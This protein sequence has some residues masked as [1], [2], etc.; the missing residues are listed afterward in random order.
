MNII[1]YNDKI[2]EIK[3]DDIIFQGSDID[4]YN[5][6]EINWQLL[7]GCNY[8]CSYCFG[9]E[10]LS[11]DFI[12]LQ[13]LKLAVDKIFQIEK[14]YYTFTLLGGEPTY[15][16]DFLELIKYIYSFTNK[17]I[18]ILVV[19]NASRN[20]EYFEKLLQ[21]VGNN[22][23]YM[24]FSVH[25]EYADI[26]HIKELILL[27][28]KYK[29]NIC[30][31][32]MLH[33]EYEEKIKNYIYEIFELNKI[34]NFTFNLAFLKEPP[35]F[36][37]ID[38]RYSKNFIDFINS[39][40]KLINEKKFNTYLDVMFPKVYFSLRNIINISIDI[41]FLLLNNL[42]I[43]KEF[44]CCGGINLISIEPNGDYRGAVC[45]EFPIVGNIYEED[46]INWFKLACIRKCNVAQCGCITNDRCNKYRDINKAKNY[47]LE[48]RKKYLNLFLLSLLNKFDEDIDNINKDIKLLDNK[49]ITLGSKMQHINDY[50]DILV[51]TIA[52]WIPIRKWRDNFRSKFA[53]ADQ[54]RPDQTRPDLIVICKGY[55][56]FYNNSK[57]KKLQP[58]LHSKNAA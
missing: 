19:S 23:F 10:L 17:N 57:T 4:D 56:Q 43:F 33:P 14:E 36:T 27:F 40:I 58:M 13:K 12:P 42:K 53:I 37:H 11:K 25:F 8:K 5:F 34:Y 22:K 46:N 20:V 49:T 2:S 54:T 3:M 24:I 7:K 30:I 47:I 39:Y 28:D 15:H 6:L 41:D 1:D 9:Q 44:Y 29:N 16:P 50:L 31:K 38:K 32:L 21:Y 35:N 48:Y 18:S 52:W 51:N 45:N 26:N 55:I